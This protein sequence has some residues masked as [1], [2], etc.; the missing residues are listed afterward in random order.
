MQN[1]FN[2][3]GNYQP[4]NYYQQPRTNGNLI[5]VNGMEG[6][7]SYQIQPNQMVM[8]LDSDNPIIYKKTAN[9]YGQATIEPFELVPIQE[10][11]QEEKYVLRTDFEALVKRIDEM[12]KKESA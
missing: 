12:T 8:L 5:F 2:P 1:N 4:N 6:A 9:A 11:K 3:Y 10:H 7:K